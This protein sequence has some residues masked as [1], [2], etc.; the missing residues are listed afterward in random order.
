MA[1]VEGVRIGG[2]DGPLRKK[3][4]I[5]ELPISS[6]K[7]SSVEGLLHVFKKK[8]EF[9]S[10]RKKVYAQFE[11]GNSKDNLLRSLQTFTDEE[12]ERD[13]IK[14]LGKDRR[15]AAPLLE[16]AAARADIYP[17]TEI[18]INEFISQYLDEAEVALREARRKEIGEDAAREEEKRGAKSDEAYAAD[19]EVRRQERAK[20]Y[21]AEL[22]L[23][24]KKEQEA[25]KKRQ[26]EALQARAAELAK[27]TER[28]QREQKRRAERE[29]AR[30]KQKQ[31]E[32]ERRK[33]FAED[34]E[35]R[36]KEQAEAAK[37]EEEEREARRKENEAAEAKRLER[38][39]QLLDALITNVAVA[40]NPHLDE[41]A[42][43]E[44]HAWPQKDPEERLHALLAPR[45]NAGPPVSR[46]LA[47]MM[48]IVHRGRE[49]HE[50]N[51]IVWTEGIADRC[52]TEVAARHV[53][54]ETIRAVPLADE[55]AA[56]RVP[57]LDDHIATETTLQA[58]EDRGH[59]P[60]VHLTLT[61]MYLVREG[62]T[63]DVTTEEMIGGMIVG[64]I[65]ET[66]IATEVETG[67]TVT[68]IT[69]GTGD[70][71][72]SRT[73]AGV[74]LET[75]RDHEAAEGIDRHCTD[76]RNCSEHG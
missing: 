66:V 43:V 42:Q 36:E 65:A 50:E 23:K 1:A 35:K 31:M 74:A 49:V 18:D 44:Y 45:L 15:L 33:K 57:H 28:L 75:V 38:E 70:D 10:L 29:A 4:K 9:D 69:I 32:E 24:R 71:L 73:T 52:G 40:P 67:G 22:R 19:A 20:K 25:A 21:A 7:R 62:E 63:T 17:T 72:E 34:R 2:D 61:D 76:V 60:E 30:A 16:G 37:R 12:I 68:G 47:G 27:E 11:A 3:P 55:T 64:T 6:A 59:G 58:D 41:A 8:G 39:A 26:L 46:V 13:P 51:L 54:E 5:S 48:M 56:G 53:G 14:Y